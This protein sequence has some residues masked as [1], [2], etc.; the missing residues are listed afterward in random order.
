MFQ[1][2]PLVVYVAYTVRAPGAGHGSLGS[3]KEEASMRKFV[4]IVVALA[5]LGFVACVA[6]AGKVSIGGKHSAD[7]IRGTCAKEGGAVF[8]VG[9]RYGCAKD[10]G[11]GKSCTVDCHDGQCTGECPRC[12]RKDESLP[13]VGG[14][15]ALE[16]TLKNS[17]KTPSKR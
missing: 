2:W 5:T 7:E 1:E 9:G 4:M 6:S 16:R 12:G 15:D 8:E 3:V 13:V 14:A 10:C 11:P 17:V